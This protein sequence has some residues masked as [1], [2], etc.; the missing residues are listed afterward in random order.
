VEIDETLG[1][2]E[3]VTA[4]KQKQNSFLKN[5]NMRK[6]LVQYTHYLSIICH[7]PMNPMVRRPP[8]LELAL[9]GFLSKEP[10]HGYQI[11]QTAS[12]LAGL[13][14][15]WYLKQSQLYALLTKLEKDGYIQGKMETQ[16]PYRPPRRVFSL[17]P[18]GRNAYHNWLVTPVDA[19]RLMRQDFMAKYYFACQEGSGSARR[20]LEIQRV[21]CQQW[22]EEAQSESVKP[23]DF[24]W[25][26]Y[27]Y[28]SGQIRSMVAWI[29]AR[30]QEFAGQ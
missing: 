18:M 7:F 17:T 14:L 21:V 5:S 29:D 27:Q 13:G 2:K 25:Q 9:L 22:L 23:G 30:L 8:G 28:R 10:Q 24:T 12:N 15:I 3:G 4:G 26:L 20:L 16:E 11:H 19:P 6:L 1:W